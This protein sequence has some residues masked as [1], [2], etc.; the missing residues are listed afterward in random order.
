MHIIL[1]INKLYYVIPKL[2]IESFSNLMSTFSEYRE[3]IKNISHKT[4]GI[5]LNS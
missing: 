2:H 1:I 5:F 4:L 3:I